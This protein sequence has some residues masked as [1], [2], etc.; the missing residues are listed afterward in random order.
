[1]YKEFIYG[2]VR[3]NLP[4]S[5]RWYA[6]HIEE[7]YRNIAGRIWR[8]HLAGN[9]ME[10]LGN[11]LHDK[12]KPILTGWVLCRNGFSPKTSGRGSKPVVRSTRPIGTRCSGTRQAAG[13]FKN[14]RVAYT[15]RVGKPPKN[16][17][18]SQKYF[19]CQ[20]TFSLIQRSHG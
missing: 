12:K 17:E 20:F 6:D 13:T 18:C 16:I 1:M 7:S 14:I 2:P 11:M 10:F 3:I 8:A 4:V 19:A 5:L 15:K 9:Q